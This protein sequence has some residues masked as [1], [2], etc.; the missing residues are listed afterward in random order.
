M[1]AAGAAGAPPGSSPEEENAALLGFRL[2]NRNHVRIHDS[3]NQNP[4]HEFPEVPTPRGTLTQTQAG[5]SRT[6]SLLLASYEPVLGCRLPPQASK[7]HFQLLLNFILFSTP[8]PRSVRYH[9]TITS[10]L[11]CCLFPVAEE[12]HHGVRPCFVVAV[13]VV[14]APPFVPYPILNSLNNA[15]WPLMHTSEK[16]NECVQGEGLG[17]C[18]DKSEAHSGL[19]PGRGLRRWRCHLPSWAS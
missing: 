3:R 2:H 18:G 11:A 1:Q 14:V 6:C 9:V 15:Q 4:M 10:G 13:V 8:V 12:K 5:S 7:Q 19:G 17:H 16:H